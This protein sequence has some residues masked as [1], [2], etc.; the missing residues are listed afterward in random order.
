MGK[1][2]SKLANLP[3]M[4]QCLF[5]VYVMFFTSEVSVQPKAEPKSHDFCAIQFC[6]PPEVSLTISLCLGLSRSSQSDDWGETVTFERLQGRLSAAPYLVPWN[7]SLK[8]HP[9]VF[10]M[11]KRCARS[12]MI[13]YSNITSWVTVWEQSANT[14]LHNHWYNPIVW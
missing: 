10:L 1:W 4:A 14:K 5:Q 13:Y 12:W 3:S 11:F 7:G 9:I 2:G 8:L 6:Y